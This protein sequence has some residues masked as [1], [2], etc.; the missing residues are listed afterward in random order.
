MTPL[1][2]S[3]MF[4]FVSELFFFD[5]VFSKA[6]GQYKKKKAKRIKIHERAMREIPALLAWF[7]VRSLVSLIT[8][9]PGG[10]Y[11]PDLRVLLARNI[12]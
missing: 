2:F 9:I 1:S 8:L 5:T 11:W 6:Y 7:P 4:L 10:G 3:E 12:K